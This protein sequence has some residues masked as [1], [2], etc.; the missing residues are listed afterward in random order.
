MAGDW[1]KMRRGLRHDPKV[2]AISRYLGASRSFMNWWS[3]PQH[4]TCAS[5]VT[6]VVTFAN[7]TRVTVASLLDVWS[8]INNTVKSDG[9][10]PFM[11]LIDIDDIA[12]VP[13]FGE[14]MQSVGWVVELDEGG[15][16]FPN[17][18]ENNT[19]AKE[20]ERPM[21][22]AE[23]SKA[24]RERKKAELGSV[25]NVT[26]RHT[27]KRREEK[28][29]VLDKSNTEKTSRQAFPEVDEFVNYCVMKL[30]EL[31]PEWTKGRSTK[32]ARL[33][34][35]TYREAGWKDGN[36]KAIKNWKTKA[37]NSLKFEKPWSY[38]TDEQDKPAQERRSAV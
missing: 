22:P 34:Y 27:E 14:A 15:L 4:H 16:M 38:G 30:E 6:E 5:H 10:A 17:F 13:D 37:L 12:E 2:I 29:I 18:G 1:I 35:E 26:S 36:G 9:I 24:Y 8:A 21:T 7:V 3:E 28:S 31:N 11:T 33:K 19:T 23:R 20:R 25:T 32:A